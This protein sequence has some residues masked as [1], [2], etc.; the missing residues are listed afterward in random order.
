MKSVFTLLMLGAT[1]T[2]I[3]HQPVMDMAPRWADGYGFQLRQQHYGSDDLM[4]GSSNTDN[5]LGVERFMDVTWLE[6]VYTFHRAMR[7]TIKVPHVNQRRVSAINGF[8]TSQRNSGFGDVV[9]GLPLKRYKNYGS[10]TQN[11]GITPSIRIPTGSSSGAF[12]ISDGSWDVGL[13]ISYSWENPRIYQLYDLYYWNEGS[14]KHGMQTGNSWGLDV[15]VGLH[16]W[17]DNDENTGIFTLWDVSVSHSA[18]PN[19]QNLTTA[20]GGDRV[21]TGPVLVYYRDSFMVRAEFKFMA[22]ERVHGVSA[23]RGNEF[24]LNLGF[25]F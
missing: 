23:S 10:T 21:Q 5:P 17:H 20:S 7:A 18:S 15:N 1:A 25:A 12:P 13:S 22:H 16:P 3:A 8:G 9:L 11:W 24:S 14:G 6:G 4:R 2:A 19:A